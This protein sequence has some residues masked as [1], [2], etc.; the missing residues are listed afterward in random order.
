MSTMTP[1]DAASL[2]LDRAVDLDEVLL[3][4]MDEVR[5]R[6]R[7][8]RCTLFLVDQAQQELVSK[9]GILPEV[10]E[11]R[12]R[13]GE[14]IAGDAA[15]TGRSLIASRRDG[16][17]RI[18]RRVDALT[19]YETRNTLVV[20]VRTHGGHIVGVMQLLNKHEGEFDEA[21]VRLAEGLAG[22]IGALIESTSLISSLLP[23]QRRPLAFRFNQIIGES[24]AMRRVY[25]RTTRAAAAEVTVLVRGGSGSGKE[26][27]ARAIHDNSPRRDGP[28]VKVDC[29]AL[30]E[31]LI[32]NE[33]FGH[34]RGAFTGADAA[35]DGKVAAAEGGTLFLDEIGELPLAVQGKLLRLLQ[36]RVYLRVGGV[37]PRPVNLRFVCATHRDLE[38][39]IAARSFRE[40]LYYRLRVV[41]IIL[42]SLRERG[43]EDL[44]RLIDHFLYTF[45]RRHGRPTIRLSAEARQR[46]H[47]HA[48]PGNVRELENCVES[49]VV[50]S[51]AELIR[52]D[53]LP[54]PGLLEPPPDVALDPSVFASA[55][56][57]LKDVE[58]AYL[59]FVLRYCGN[60]R[61]RAAKL[62]GISRNTLARKLDGIDG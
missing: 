13:L 40:D 27:I 17:D 20:P 7:A 50:L 49:A 41:E 14:G 9:L 45:G 38:Q 31:S 24:V 48:W 62:M 52:P 32:E 36:E 8:D 39:A 26:L 25:E 51:P 18:L 42:P 56:G 23:D 54:L 33:L 11:I 12:L 22:Q 58:R 35:A 43:A 16:E 59:Q 19:G 1:L 30:P 4:L 15:R 34:E 6:M 5:N 60:N 3:R 29:A 46:L 44:D 47:L 55:I 21:D 10:A 57:P 28:F 53:A 61:S 37:K 2:V